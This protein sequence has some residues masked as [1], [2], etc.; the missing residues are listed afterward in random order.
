[1]LELAGILYVLP[2]VVQPRKLPLAV[3]TC[4]A[5]IPRVGDHVAPEILGTGKGL[6]AF[7]AAMLAWC[8]A[9]AQ[10]PMGFHQLLGLK[11]FWAVTGKTGSVEMPGPA[12]ACYKFRY[13][14]G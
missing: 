4:V 5:S 6:G 1:M 7:E 13:H 12:W 9:V 14:N 3:P 8:I 2:K 11:L 10:L